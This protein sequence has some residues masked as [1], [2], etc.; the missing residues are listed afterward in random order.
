MS[1]VMSFGVAGVVVLAFM[2]LTPGRAEAQWKW[3]KF[4]DGNGNEFYYPMWRND[5]GGNQARAYLY[6]ATGD[7]SIS[8][9]ATLN[10]ATLK[11]YTAGAL[12]MSWN[13]NEDLK[14]VDD[15]P[16]D[17]GI[18]PNVPMGMSKKWLVT[19]SGAVNNPTLFVKGT[20]VKL[21]VILNTTSGGVTSDSVITINPDT[22]TVQVR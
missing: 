12:P 8:A 3:N 5:P 7:M 16:V 21:Q 22:S 14:L 11:V 10:K 18:D 19:W 9:T 4:P 13:A 20:I 17:R 2:A 6:L 1:R 15:S